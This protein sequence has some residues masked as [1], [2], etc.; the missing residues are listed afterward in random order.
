MEIKSSEATWRGMCARFRRRFPHA[1]LWLGFLALVALF[2]GFDIQSRPIVLWDESRVVSNALE[3]SR[4]GAD[5][6]H[7]L[8]LKTGPVEHQ[9]APGDLARRGLDPPVRRL[10]MVDAAPS[11]IAA[12]ATVAIAMKMTWMRADARAV[13]SA[14]LPAVVLVLSAGFYRAAMPPNPRTYT[15]R[16]G[17]DLRPGASIGA[18][19]QA[20]GRPVAARVRDCAAVIEGVEGRL[21]D[22][23]SWCVATASGPE[24]SLRY[25]SRQRAG[26]V[27]GSTE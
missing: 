26:P 23:N 1:Y 8:R 6:R 25:G 7:H 11:L 3:M 2:L 13:G 10:G 18:D 22:Q 14:A 20:F 17:G 12:V 24:P 5:S 4:T 9:A 15:R 16:R 27:R 21:S 19:A